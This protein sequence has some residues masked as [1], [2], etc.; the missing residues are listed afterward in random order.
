MRERLFRPEFLHLL[1]FV[2]YANSQDKNN[3]GAA[4][5]CHNTSMM[6]LE[7]L[8]KWLATEIITSQN[9]V[10]GRFD[11][12]LDTE[13]LDRIYYQATSKVRGFQFNLKQIID[14]CPQNPG[15]IPAS[16]LGG[17][18]NLMYL[19]LQNEKPALTQPV[20]ISPPPAHFLSN[21]VD[22]SEDKAMSACLASYRI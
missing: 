17:L 7:R 18:T 20:K 21:R 5:A 9:S 3:L 6:L 4:L 10:E 14:A 13:I 1:A 22:Y 2:F 12:V 8:I 16:D 19:L 15:V 11:Y